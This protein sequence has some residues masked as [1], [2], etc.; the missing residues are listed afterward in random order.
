MKKILTGFTKS[1]SLYRG[2]PRA[3]YAIFLAQIV[4]AVGNLV[5]PFLTF[6]LTQRLGFD[7]GAAGAF[8]FVASTAFVPGSLIG[9]KL[10]DTLGRKVVLIT[11]QGLAAAFLIPCAFL[12][13][14]PVIPWLIIGS[15]FFGGVANPCHEAI[16]TDLTR[17]DQRQAAF[18]LLY[19]GHNIG[20]AVGPLIAGFLFVHALPWLFLG[21]VI[22]TFIALGFVAVLVPETKPTEEEVEE[23]GGLSSNEKAEKGGLI[24]VLLKRPFLLAFAFLSL[25][26]TFVYSQYTFSLPLQMEFLYPKSGPVLYGT[27]MTV[28]ALV[29]IFLTTPAIAITKSIRPLI[30]VAI[31]SLLFALGFGM[32]FLIRSLGFFILSTIIWTIGEILQA[33]NTNVY[34]AN[35]TPISH[36]G[37][38]N[39]VLPIIMGTG[40]AMGPPVM[41]QYIETFGVTA[42]WSLVFFISLFGAVALLFLYR[43]ERRSEKKKEV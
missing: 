2:L 34:I 1:F 38:F 29:V 32:I 17:V 21:D 23:H 9:G 40:F 12:G 27:L 14:S 18:S 16:T 43:L 15:N 25:L 10:A 28:N 24:P 11:A 7:S 33:T 35:H 19:L 26:L 5:Y 8:I 30:V 37:R 13:A 31:S 41:G 39:S 3:I 36:R 6:F 20:F 4:N 22:T 42:V